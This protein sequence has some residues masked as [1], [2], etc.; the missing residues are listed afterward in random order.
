M[1][2]E[3]EVK[4][5]DIKSNNFQ[6]YNGFNSG[7]D[8]CECISNAKSN[9]VI[10]SPYLGAKE[11]GNDLD[12]KESNANLEGNKNNKDLF[13]ALENAVSKNENNENFNITIF[14]SYNFDEAIKKIDSE[15]NQEERKNLDGFIVFVDKIMS[16]NNL[17]SKITFKIINQEIYNFKD[18]SKPEEK[19]F[20]NFFHSKIFLIDESILFLGSVNST[21]SAFTF[22]VETRIKFTKP[23]E[24]QEGKK[25][26]IYDIFEKYPKYCKYIMKK[27]ED[28]FYTEKEIEDGIDKAKKIANSEYKYPKYPTKE[29]LEKVQVENENLKEENEKLKD[30][31]KNLV[32]K[33]KRLDSNIEHLVH[34]NSKLKTQLI[35][36]NNEK[37][38]L[39]NENDLLVNRYNNLSEKYAGLKMGI[40]IL[41]WICI[42]FILLFYFYS[43]N[44]K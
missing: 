12:E 30:E 40:K 4:M 20:Y 34:D 32:V 33:N 44:L 29:K 28:Y 41:V 17:K 10:M 36:S 24:S 25:G 42:F 15:K 7:K 19:I 23:V 31:N 43:Q 5:I 22:N 21:K 37:S 6:I 13:S 3:K 26:I 1:G 14:S 11:S 27:Y 35:D 39:R 8:I 2:Q 9:I 16:D 18:I 38:S